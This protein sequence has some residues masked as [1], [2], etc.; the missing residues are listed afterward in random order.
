MQAWELEECADGGREGLEHGC[1]SKSAQ[2]NGC[3]GCFEAGGLA[4][5]GYL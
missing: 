2:V 3:R 1:R 5:F 4:G